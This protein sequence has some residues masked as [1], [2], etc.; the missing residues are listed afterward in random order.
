MAGV[1]R[2]FSRFFPSVRLLGEDRAAHWG[3]TELHTGG[4]GSCTQGEEGAEGSVHALELSNQLREQWLSLLSDGRAHI[5][6]SKRFLL[7]Y[8]TREVAQNL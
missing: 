3:R 4:G 5:R 2:L 1:H 6:I 7:R 8:H